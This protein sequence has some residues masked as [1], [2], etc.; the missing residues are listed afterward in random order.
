MH[1]TASVEALGVASVACLST[2][3]IPQAQFCAD[4]VGMPALPCVFAEHPISD[5]T[6]GQLNA[7]A[8]ACVMEI[9]EALTEAPS[10][11]VKA[12]LAGS[13]GKGENG[14]AAAAACST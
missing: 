8:D 3:F 9:I 10:T 11:R 6:V 4:Q 2:A 14:E 5:Q 7:K 1:D 12:K 13:G